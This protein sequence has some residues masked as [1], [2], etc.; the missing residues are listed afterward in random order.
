MP[1]CPATDGSSPRQ[2]T[3]DG[4]FDMCIDPSKRY[5]A[6]MVTS[7]GSLTIALDPAAAP[8]TAPTARRPR[9]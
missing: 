5:T 3:F 1:E 9:A 2:T 6:E 7:M 4:P 8:N